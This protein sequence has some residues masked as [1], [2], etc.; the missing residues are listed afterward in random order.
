MTV[1]SPTDINRI[2][3]ARRVEVRPVLNIVPLEVV[4]EATVAINA[5][6]PM[7]QLSVDQTVTWGNGDV[8]RAF[9]VITDDGTLIK[10]WGVQ[11]K[12]SVSFGFYPDVKS[13]GDGG[14]ARTI[15]YPILAGDKV[16]ICRHRPPFGLISRTT[17]DGQNKQWDIPYA[18][19]GSRPD[20][21]IV[22]GTHQQQF[23]DAD[24]YAIFSFDA[25]DSF[26][27]LYMQ[28]GIVSFQ[29]TLPGA[30]QVLS[31]SAS[32]AAVTFR[33]PKG[34][35]EIGLTITSING[36]ISRG[37][38]WCFAN[39]PDPADPD[40][41]FSY[42]FGVES[43]ADSRNPQGREMT[44]TFR[45]SPAALRQ[46]I[47]PGAMCVFTDRTL[48]D[49]EELDTAAA[50]R[51]F[52]GYLDE[53]SFEQSRASG[54]ATLKFAGPLRAARSIPTVTQFVQAVANPVAWTDV[55][56][57][58]SHPAFIAYYILKHHTGLLANH[59]FILQQDDVRLLR[60]PGYS[61]QQ[62]QIGAQL[63]AAAQL[64]AGEF[65]ARS[66]GTFTL[67]YE[68]S[69][70]ETTERN[71][72]D[73]KFTWT[74]TDIRGPLR[75]A[76]RLRPDVGQVIM[77][78]LAWD[79]V[80]EAQP[81]RALAPGYAQSQ[82]IGQNTESA[83]MVR[84]DNAQERLERIIGHR[85]AYLNNALEAL[86]AAPVG[87]ADICEPA[88]AD[89][90]LVDVPEELLAF[91]PLR[92][93]LDWSPVRVRPV[94]V[95]CQWRKTKGGW[96]KT[97][98]ITFRAETFGRRGVFLPV[99][100]GGAASIPDL[101]T[102]WIDTEN[103]YRPAPPEYELGAEYAFALAWNDQGD[104]G[105]TF[106]FLDQ[107][108][109]YESARGEGSG[110]GPFSGRVLWAAWIKS[111]VFPAVG[112]LVL[113]G[114]TIRLYVV[115]DI[116]APA[117]SL[118]WSLDFSETIDPAL[119]TGWA[120]VTFENGVACA[121]WLM[122]NGIYVKRSTGSW[123]STTV[124]GSAVLDSDA[125]ANRLGLY[126]EP[127]SLKIYISG[128]VGVDG[129]YR[130]YRATG[131]GA[132]AQVPNQLG[133]PYPETVQMIQ[134]QGLGQDI[135]TTINL[136]QTFATPQTFD[137]LPIAFQIARSIVENPLISPGPPPPIPVQKYGVWRYYQTP[138]QGTDGRVYDVS[139]L[140]FE[141]QTEVWQ[142]SN[143][144]PP[145][146]P[147]DDNP[148]GPNFQ[149]ELNLLDE[150]GNTLWSSG[151]FRFGLF[152]AGNPTTGFS[153]TGASGYGFPFFA[154]YTRRQK[155]DVTFVT[156]IQ[157]VRY[158]EV[159]IESEDELRYAYFQNG[160]AELRE[161]EIRLSLAKF[162]T[163]GYAVK[164]R[165]LYR[166]SST[167]TWTNATPGDRAVPLHPLG[168]TAFGGSSAVMIATTPQKQ[169]NLYETANSGGSWSIRK[170]NSRYTWLKRLASD[171]YVAGGEGRLDFSTNGLRT[172]EPRIG[173]WGRTVGVVG[174]IEGA[175]ILVEI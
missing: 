120:Q 148:E 82:G 111:A 27:W 36:R 67:T 3:T 171:I 129:Q 115:N 99:D 68:P 12:P 9:Y 170:P 130:L 50:V 125:S 30:A 63:Q 154:N 149:A 85:W 16:K 110:N 141:F 48:F 93:G 116:T 56:P 26:D 169:R 163:A 54:S 79:G 157:A 175:L 98:N 19:Q 11:R 49:G 139:R 76:P 173:D 66:D 135:Y 10:T 174:R 65:N 4:A 95:N 145:Y 132:F 60:R 91:D 47:Y 164:G 58:F 114:S 77:D 24:G 97:P 105:R 152:T 31:G 165:R 35:Y 83:I 155:I 33:V 38:R 18:G 128:A 143:M 29:Y 45:A 109:T 142:P 118:N 71:A 5:V 167:D 70:L 133:S 147:P 57:E 72:V 78:A 8:G 168:L 144:T 34:S 88:D 153:L 28:A 53:A 158:M 52:V 25:S 138:A 150:E 112:V 86:E 122:L 51:T 146:W 121:A 156:P 6:Y 104:L 92:F 75:L 137:N 32:S 20:P 162:W 23:V 22:M 80:N 100:R 69:H 42:R 7:T 107:T 55:L 166:V 161:L 160:G 117:N 74:A 87:M 89:W 39:S 37:Y 134:S 94:A 127:T 21:V 151:L 101:T 62:N 124:V 17:A 14:Y 13:D 40:A 123:G 126:I 172:A 136:N 59:D 15:H 64:F 96:I 1:L 106:N 90:H 61:F 41:P 131:L 113:Q 2:R 140:E 46:A 43:I 108:V 159:R 44:F 119:F 102:G 73:T 81:Y 103:Y 84:P